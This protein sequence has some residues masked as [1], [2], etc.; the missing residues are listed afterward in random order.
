MRGED[1]V[2]DVL[3]AEQTEKV[4]RARIAR[5]GKKGQKNSQLGGRTNAKK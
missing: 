1:V 2:M 3:M 5:W 4:K